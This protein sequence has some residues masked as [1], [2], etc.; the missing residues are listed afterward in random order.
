MPFVDRVNAVFSDRADLRLE[1]VFVNDGSS[2]GTLSQLLAA[3]KMHRWIRIVDLSRNFG[4]EAALTAGLDHATGDAVVPIDVDLQD[5]PEVILA[6]I[7]KWSEGYEVVLGKYL[8]RSKEKFLKRSTAR[9][10]YA[11]HNRI[12]DVR[13]PTDS[14]DFRLM[15]RKVVEALRKL[16]ESQ[17]FMK[18]LF[19]WAGFRT[20][21][22]TYERRL[23]ALGSTSFSGVKLWNLALDGLTGFS[24]VPL[25]VW[26]Y[27]GTLVALISFVYATVI[28][29]RTLVLGIDV[30]GY[31][32]L[33]VMIM[34]FAGIQLIGIGIIG[35]YLARVF[36]EA[37]RRPIYLVREVIEGHE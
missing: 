2:D 25:K 31:A 7:S 15:D 3:Q 24:T 27:F 22:V 30:P 10:F 32:S 14:G 16:P 17:R 28:I 33:A 19:A 5:S 4:K 20:A 29:A 35:E 23:R 18:G 36:I 13:L 21:Q 12:A 9:A 6:M 34:F 8:D 26:T 37:K 11:L 1:M